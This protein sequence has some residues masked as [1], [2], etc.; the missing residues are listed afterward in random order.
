LSDSEDLSQYSDEESVFADIESISLASSVSISDQALLKQAF[1]GPVQYRKTT[2]QDWRN[3]RESKFVDESKAEIDPKEVDK[4]RN[5]ASQDS[6][7]LAQVDILR[8]EVHT[9]ALRAM[10]TTPDEFLHINKTEK[11]D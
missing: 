7:P 8:Q 2:A 11:L 3:E 5:Y 10:T 4:S 9:D 1:R 6:G